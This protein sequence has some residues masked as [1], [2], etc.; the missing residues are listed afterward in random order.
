M[1]DDRI[2]KNTDRLIENGKKGEGPLAGIMEAKR[3]TLQDSLI[4]RNTRNA[5]FQSGSVLTSQQLNAEVEQ[6]LNEYAYGKDGKSGLRNA[7]LESASGETGK[8]QVE[9]KN[10]GTIANSVAGMQSALSSG[11]MG[12]LS[13]F[14]IVPTLIESLGI[15]DFV[16]GLMSYFFTDR[17]KFS[18]IGEAYEH[19]KFNRG[20]HAFSE[21]IQVNAEE[22]KK[23]L[24]AD[25][26]KAA[27]AED[28]AKPNAPVVFTLG[29][30]PPPN[31]AQG[32]P[33]PAAGRNP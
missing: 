9:L 8:A 20:I 29:N 13:V 22:L 18:S 23:E 2:I 31:P 25:P 3:T 26:D 28:S 33:L 6:K 27:K 21:N 11:P 4:A 10:I 17:G 15:G 14:S 32:Q 24:L 7:M 12:L 19:A 16:S 5:Q 30:L 1:V